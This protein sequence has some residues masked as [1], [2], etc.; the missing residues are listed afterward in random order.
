[1]TNLMP[2]MTMHWQEIGA[3]QAGTVVGVALDGRGRGLLASRAGVYGWRQPG[4]AVEPVTAGLSDFNVVAVA[5]AGG[6]ANTP[7]TA[8][9]ATATGRLFRLKPSEVH[10]A[11]ERWQE[12][13]SWA[14]LGV[15][16]VLQP[17][18]AFE[19]D[20]TLFAGTPT[21]IYRTQDGGQSWESCNFGLMDEDVLCVVCAPDFAESELMW[22]G[23][24]GGGL[25]RSRNRARAWR[26]AGSGLPDAAVQCLAAS[27]NFVE[28][29]TLFA[30]IEANGIYV[31][32]DGGENWES[33]GLATYSVNTLACPRLDVLWAGTDDG[34][35]RVT[36]STGEAVQM[37]GDGDVVLAVASSAEGEIA[38]GLFGRG[39]LV[40][41]EHQSIAQSVTWQSPTVAVHA[42]PVIASIGDEFFAVDSEG[43]MASSQDGGAQWVEMESASEE[44]VIA[45]AT[46]AAQDLPLYAATATG[47]SC[48]D[49]SQ[50]QW[51]VVALN[52][53]QEQSALAVELSPDLA[54]DHT[55]LVATNEGEIVLS[56]DGGIHWRS[57]TGPWLGQSLLRVH[58]APSNASE[59]I[60]LTMQPGENGHFAITAWHTINLG[61]IW[62]VLASFTTALPAVMMAWPADSVEHAIFLATQHRV[63]KLY[64]QVEPQNL[65]VHQHFFDETL[66]VT[67]LAAASG[68]GESGIVWAATTGGLYRSVDRGM[69]WGLVLELPLGLPLVWLKVLPTQVRAVTLGGR[70]WRASIET[71]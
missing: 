63:I 7:A 46:N 60:A 48:W 26:D 32:R 25:Y 68:F 35:W 71:S 62:E 14:G 4:I 45:L 33:L 17:S 31:S 51:Q 29:R 39:L 19:Q 8:L 70:V 36:T 52:P 61:Q 42:P 66:R 11:R 3:W 18:P 2:I 41:Q 38:A 9:A 50:K 12:I 43:F 54:S 67:A 23:T 22:A 56:Q 13:R 58:F 27:P 55:L 16:V 5:F 64:T 40:G 24:A 69:S 37:S 34:L 57:I 28:D 15:A 53:V 21:G 44:G 6:D 65:Q 47:L 49:R 10:L 20:Q 30:G 1:M 59:I